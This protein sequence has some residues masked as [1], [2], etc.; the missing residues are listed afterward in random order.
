MMNVIIVINGKCNTEVTGHDESSVLISEMDS[1]EESFSLSS[2]DSTKN[3]N[4][5]EIF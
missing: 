2:T 1:A 5:P 3:M 4:V